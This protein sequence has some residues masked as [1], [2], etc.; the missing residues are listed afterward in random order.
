MIPPDLKDRVAALERLAP[1]VPQVFLHLFA[2]LP[3]PGEEFSAEQRTAFLR[4]AASVAD[5]V[6]GPCPMKIEKD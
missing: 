4:A 3:P 1:N 5:V 2:F 6:Y